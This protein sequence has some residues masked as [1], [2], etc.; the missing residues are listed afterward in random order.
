MNP[1]V[2]IRR[3]PRGFTLIE[4]SLVIGLLLGLTT[5]VGFNVTAVRKWQLAKDASMS[6][7]A[8]YAAQ[9]AYLAD[10]PTVNVGQV[11]SAQL[12]AY[13]PQGWSTMPVFAG[14]EGESL[15]LDHSVMPPRLLHNAAVYD[16][17]GSGTD[18]LWD[19]GK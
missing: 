6:L 8:V 11:T 13:L 10:H 16:P 7:Q 12:Q 3:R 14:E 1:P 15:L 4:I 9:R 17:S 2:S 18:G 5:L 19:T